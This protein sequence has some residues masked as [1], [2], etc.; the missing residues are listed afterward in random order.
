MTTPWQDRYALRT[1]G[2]RS[3]IIRELLKLA[4]Q[5]DVIS[6]GGGI[7][8]AEL[9]PLDR[10][11]EAADKVLREQGAKALQY[12]TTEGYPPLRRFVVEQMQRYGMNIQ[13]DNVLITSGSQQA[14]DLAGKVLLNPGDRI[15]TE[16][17]TYLGALQSWN[18]YQ[19]RYV[20]VPIDHDGLQVDLLEEKLRVGPKLMYIMP[21]FQNP[22]G[23]SL[24]LE[25][26]VK[27]VQMA[28]A[29]GVPIVEDDAYGQ[30]RYSGEQLPPLVA[31]DAENLAS[32]SRNGRDFAAGNVIYTS[33]FSKTLAPGLRLGW[34]VAP[35]EVIQR[36]V[37][38]KQGADLHT[39]TLNQMVAY[40]V[41]K[42]GFLDAHTPRLREVY[43]RRR[44]VMLAAMDRYFPAELT[45]TR[46]DGGLFI[47]VWLPDEI[48]TVALLPEAVERYKV[49]F[50]PGTAFYADGSGHHTMR[51]SFSTS[52]PNLIE[53]GIRR[54]GNLLKA[55]LVDAGLTRPD[56]LLA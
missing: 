16:R 32:H 51:L 50:V 47:W 42:E 35:A 48:D 15:L 25:R 13:E 9:F 12:S 26:R 29:Y 19:A 49:A 1:E 41:A 3:S 33:T 14:L 6:F 22:G 52:A 46:P 11:R 39:S 7:P 36:C 10:F 28:D 30:L 27:L 43:A 5:P 20:S 38:A 2:M 17:P 23:V 18:S 8:A 37:Q 56:P 54:L 31:L 4:A 24:S 53:E 55:K 21:N 34:I 45:W 40:E 44:D